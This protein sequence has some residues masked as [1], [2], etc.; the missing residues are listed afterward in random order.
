MILQEF[1]CNKYI[2]TYIVNMSKKECER[3]DLRMECTYKRKDDHKY[4]ITIFVG[5]KSYDL[6]FEYLEDIINS[7]YKDLKDKIKNYILSRI[8]KNTM[9]KLN[10]FIKEKVIPET[11][12]I[13]ECVGKIYKIDSTSGKKYY[14]TVYTDHIT[15]KKGG[16]VDVKIIEGEYTLDDVIDIIKKEDMNGGQAK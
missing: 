1:Y 12:Y 13:C 2:G 9:A 4:Q 8:N 3:T 14:A 5:V 6:M 11:D 10:D 15:I 7:N 16:S